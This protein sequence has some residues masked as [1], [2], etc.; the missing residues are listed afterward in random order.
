[1]LQLFNT[2]FFSEE[3]VIIAFI[4]FLL[5]FETTKKRYECYF[6]IKTAVFTLPFFV[7]SKLPITI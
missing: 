6:C 2:N 3:E 5:S 1:M 4:F 7:G